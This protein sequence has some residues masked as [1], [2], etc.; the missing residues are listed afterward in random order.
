MKMITGR[1]RHLEGASGPQGEASP[2]WPMDQGAGCHV[3]GTHFQVRDLSPS[4]T[5]ARGGELCSPLAP[6][7][8]PGKGVG[9]L[10]AIF[11]AVSPRHAGVQDKRGAGR[12]H[13]AAAI[14]NNLRGH[15]AVPVF[16]PNCAASR[17]LEG[18]ILEEDRCVLR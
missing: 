7:S 5:P 17:R 15:G 9:G 6:P 16:D 4:P 13:I 2:P 1:A 14:A 12:R 10:G 11:S 3:G 8:L 18:M